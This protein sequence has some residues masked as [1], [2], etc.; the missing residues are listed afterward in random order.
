MINLIRDVFVAIAALGG[1]VSMANQSANEPG[2][3]VRLRHHRHHR[4]RRFRTRCPG[5]G[6]P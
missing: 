6:I 3:G 2:R 1:G 4:V 5:A